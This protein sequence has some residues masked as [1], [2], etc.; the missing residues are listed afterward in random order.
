MLYQHENIKIAVRLLANDVHMQEYH[1]TASP[2]GIHNEQKWTSMVPITVGQTLALEYRIIGLQRSCL[3]DIKVDGIWR[4]R[5]MHGSQETVR[6]LVDSVMMKGE[7]GLY[8]VKMCAEAQS[9]PDPYGSDDGEDDDFAPVKGSAAFEVGNIELHFFAAQT[10][11]GS[12]RGKDYSYRKGPYFE[13]DSVPSFTQRAAS[14]PKLTSKVYQEAGPATCSIAFSKRRRLPEA[15]EAAAKFDAKKALPGPVP[16]VSFKFLYRDQS[17][18]NYECEQPSQDITSASVSSGFWATIPSL[19]SDAAIEST[20]E[21]SQV[22]SRKGAKKQK[23]RLARAQE[24]AM[25]AADSYIGPE[26]SAVT[27]TVGAAPPLELERH[28]TNN[29]PSGPELITPLS[30]VADTVRDSSSVANTIRKSP[31]VT[32]TVR[33]SS[34][35]KPHQGSNRRIA[36][37]VRFAPEA[38]AESHPAS[39][40]T[41]AHTSY[42]DESNVVTP[43]APQEDEGLNFSDGKY[44]R[45]LS[46]IGDRSETPSRRLYVG[47]LGPET[48]EQDLRDLFKGFIMYETSML[49]F[50]CMILI[51]PLQTKRGN[52]SC[53]KHTEASHLWLRNYQYTSRS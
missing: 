49:L 1:V 11:T 2:T 20:P 51:Y 24:A 36:K 35:A 23:R 4:V 27:S 19:P 37:T 15:E 21:T 14:D 46:K 28:I 25:A 39:A 6:Q 42:M 13:N 43:A 8:Y 17:V 52:S 50:K 29:I 31:P 12:S 48:T 41:L 18:L 10:E 44:V 47:N 34:L 16:F 22:Q 45:C 7:Q 26:Q 5:K 53:P 3:V 38:S 30:P 33:K 40:P 9:S 32:D